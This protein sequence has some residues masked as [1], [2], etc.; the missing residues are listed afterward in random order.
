VRSP[1]SAGWRLGTVRL[2]LAGLLLSMA[3]MGAA[4]AQ[5]S[6]PAPPPGPDRSEILRAIEEVKADPNLSA[7]RTIRML[8]WKDQTEAKR[9]TPGWV[10]WIAGLFGWLEQSARVLV[11]CLA[12]FLIGLLILFVTRLV[13][14]RVKR[15]TS[16]AFTAPTHVRDL[17]IRPESLPDD[18]GRA[19]RALW[20][21]GDH[22]A[23]LALLY[24]GL[25]SR[26]AHAHHAPILDSST[27]GDCLALAA[28][29]L[30]SSR[31]DYASRLVRVWQ[32]AVYAGEPAEPVA[33]YTLCDGFAAALDA[34]VSRD[35]APA[36]DTP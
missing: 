4:F 20:D 27:E 13:R 10:N 14:S 12:L 16:Q 25:L 17:D 11:W 24:R 23:A 33:V 32:R 9:P 2:A 30:A 26:L 22:R 15:P 3:P 28:S 36:G 31:Y 6:E 29:H 34:A 1:H 7:Q 21:R 8:R 19:A 18:I 5:P 35:S